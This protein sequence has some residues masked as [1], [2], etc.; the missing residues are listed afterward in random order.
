MTDKN[1]LR[2]HMAKKEINNNKLAKLLGI[3]ESSLYRKINGASDF[4]RNEIQIIRKELDLSD[5]EVMDIFFNEN[6]A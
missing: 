6:L 5:A 1:L 3:S 2:Y 4:T